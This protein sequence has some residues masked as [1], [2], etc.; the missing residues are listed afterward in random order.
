MRKEIGSVKIQERLLKVFQV[1]DNLFQLVLVE[2][3]EI[4]VKGV[5]EV[6]VTKL[7]FSLFVRLHEPLRRSKNGLTYYTLD[8]FDRFLILHFHALNPVEVRKDAVKKGYLSIPPSSKWS[9]GIRPIPT[10]YLGIDSKASAICAVSVVEETVKDY[11]EELEQKLIPFRLSELSHSQLKVLGKVLKRERLS[12]EEDITLRKGLALGPFVNDGYS[13]FLQLKNKN[14]IN[15][16]PDYASFIIPKTNHVAIPS[17]SIPDVVEVLTTM[18]EKEKAFVSVVDEVAYGVTTKGKLF[19]LPLEDARQK[20]RLEICNNGE[21]S[22]TFKELFKGFVE[23][24]FMPALW[25][26]YLK[27][28]NLSAVRIHALQETRV[29]N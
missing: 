14:V 17:G 10:H 5:C 11:F 23:E 18:P 7:I 19:V 1:S 24:E 20:Y 16:E 25:Q 26:Y 4:F 13:I 3:G 8:T 28:G 27:G 2:P 12:E 6:D 29:P 9:T 22:E 15:V 21:C